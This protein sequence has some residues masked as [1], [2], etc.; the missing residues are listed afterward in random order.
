MSAIASEDVNTEYMA[1]LKDALFEDYQGVSIEVVSSQQLKDLLINQYHISD[2]T[3]TARALGLLLKKM[4]YSKLPKMVRLK[5]TKHSLWTSLSME[6]TATV[7]KKFKESM[8]HGRS[9]TSMPAITEEN[10]DGEYLNEFDY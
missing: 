10:K 3:L 2:N 7:V 4:N 6:D 8:Q 5:G 9:T 1:E